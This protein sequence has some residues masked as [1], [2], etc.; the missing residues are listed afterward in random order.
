MKI[1]FNNDSVELHQGN[2]TLYDL[3]AHFG[4][5]QTGLAD[6]VVAHNGVLISKTAYAKT[7]VNENDA[8]DV[9]S[10]ITGG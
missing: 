8:I 5:F 3:L 2:W 4:F 1:K 10:V 9:L 7:L 6:F